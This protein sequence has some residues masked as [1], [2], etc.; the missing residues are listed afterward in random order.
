MSW[1]SKFS[2]TRM[3]PSGP[4]ISERERRR[5]YD[6]VRESGARYDGAARTDLPAIPFL[7]FGVTYDVDL[8]LVSDHPDWD[9][10]E[11]ARI[12]THEGDLWLAKDSLSSTGDQLLVADIPDLHDW[13]PEVPLA[14]RRGHVE[15]DDRSTDRWLDLTLHY[16]NHRGDAVEAHYAGRPPSSAQRQRN[17]STMGHSRRQVMAV[18]DVSHRDFA[19]TAKISIGGVNHPIHRVAGLVPMQLALRQTQ[20]G[21]ARA[22]YSFTGPSG[23][24]HDLV[25]T[26]RM[27]DGHVASA[28][29]SLQERPDRLV[30]SQRSALR[31][32]R[33]EFACVEG[34]F[35]LHTAAVL[36]AISP[37]HHN[38]SITFA[39]TL[40]DLRFPL[41][42]AWSGKWVMDVGDQRN[43][44]VG[45]ITVDTL[46]GEQRVRVDA[47]KPW[48]VADRAIRSSVAFHDEKI[49]VETIVEPG[50]G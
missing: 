46:E 34:R 50:M 30:V 36:P 23:A 27:G 19:R 4:V 10:H 47:E 8:V 42:K 49:E 22:S 3:L 13:L 37:E 5:D 29:W 45:S 25:S 41:A 1:K 21:L 18:L 24:P 40:P 12:T 32:L 28:A 15:V 39:P 31:T 26:H 38:F 11:Y 2:L 14:R 16:E 33:Y 7:V 48:W 20:G 9:M 44:A 43:H 17:G 35:E 6:P